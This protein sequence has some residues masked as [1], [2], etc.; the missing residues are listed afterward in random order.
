[1]LTTINTRWEATQRVMAVKLTRLTHKIAIQL[2]LVVDSYT[3]C[4]SRSRRPVRKLLDTPSYTG[5][6]IVRSFLD[7]LSRNVPS[8]VNFQGK[9]HRHETGSRF[10][11]V[12]FTVSIFRLLQVTLHWFQLNIL[13]TGYVLRLI[14]APF[15]TS[16]ACNI[17]CNTNKNEVLLRQSVIC[18]LQSSE[19]CLQNTTK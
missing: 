18:N 17:H 12:I 11:P 3:I 13:G 9:I 1:M 19:M 2:H 16:V 4:S 5:S 7:G 10:F 6:G 14:Q 15:H 8:K